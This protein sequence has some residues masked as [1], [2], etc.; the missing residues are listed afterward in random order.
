M[1]LLFLI[2]A[3][4]LVGCNS[5]KS[6]VYTGYVEGEFR[7]LS[8][9]ES[10]VISEIKVSKGGFVTKDTALAVMEITGAKLSI[11][12]AEASYSLAKSEFERSRILA[13]DG[14]ISKAAAEKIAAEFETAE[15]AYD[16]AKWHLS[17]HTIKAPTD[18]YIQEIL[19][20]EGELATS[21]NPVIYFLPK[22][23][24]KIRFFVPQDQLVNIKLGGKVVVKVDGQPKP[25]SATIKF[26]SNQAEFTPPIIYSNASRDKLVFMIEAAVDDQS[27][28]LLL[29]PGQPADVQ[30]SSVNE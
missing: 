26:I 21:Q 27:N 8:S 11:E 5:K 15:A 9:L 25:V 18:G 19:R 16:Q 10:G 14:V 30:L 4:M 13:K 17:R 2:G 28:D 3:L 7:L 29:K 24:I 12:Q 22:S 1:R 23:N 6:D 20:Y